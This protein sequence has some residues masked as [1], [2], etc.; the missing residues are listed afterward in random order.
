[1]PV[2]G[3]TAWNSPDAFVGRN[4]LSAFEPYPIVSGT[5]YSSN[6]PA[7]IEFVP[8]IQPTPITVSNIV[9]WFAL[10]NA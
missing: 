9:D 3:P 1:M 5:A 4:V 7:S 2:T 8:W 6:A 10:S